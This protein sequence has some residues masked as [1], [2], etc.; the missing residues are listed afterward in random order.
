MKYLYGELRKANFGS[1]Y[2]RSGCF[3]LL[4]TVGEAQ[5]SIRTV[6]ELINLAQ[7][8][9]F[10]ANAEVSSLK[11]KITQEKPIVDF[12]LYKGSQSR[13]MGRSQSYNK[14][15]KNTTYILPAMPR[16]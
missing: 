15:S 3:A 7:C 16:Y 10:A 4:K 11:K 6:L 1:V 9:Y 8:L 12:Y 2:L 13:P 14:I 5:P